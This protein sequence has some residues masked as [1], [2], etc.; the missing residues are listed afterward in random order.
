MLTKCYHSVVFSNDFY[1]IIIHLLLS[2]L[3]FIF[4][5]VRAPHRNLATHVF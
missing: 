3:L 5:Q 1:I 4:Y 2:I